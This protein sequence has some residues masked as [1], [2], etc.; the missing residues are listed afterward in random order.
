VRHFI[1]KILVLFVLLASLASQQAM[2]LDITNVRFGA[3]PD[4]TRMVVDLNKKTDFRTFVLPRIDNKPYRLVVDLPSFNWKAGDIP[5][6]A[7]TPVIDVRSGT[8]S[9]NTKRIVVDLKQAV[10]I[11]GA[12]ILPPSGAMPHRLVIDF[13]NIT[14]KNFKSSE[15]KILGDL[16]VEIVS[17]PSALQKIITSQTTTTKTS[18]AGIPIP[19]RKP[20]ASQRTKITSSVAT[21]TKFKIRT[22]LRKRLIVIDAGHGGQDPGAIGAGRAYE[23]NVTL[24]AA[25]VLRSKLQS[26]GR[27]NVIL[28][29]DSDKYLK[30]YQRRNIARKK[31]ADLFISLHADS[32]GKSNVRGASIYTLS[33]KS[34]DAQTAKLAARENQ[35]DLIAGVD[36]SHEDKDVANILIDLAMRDTM[37]QSKFFANTVVNN[38]KNHGIRTLPK[39][40]RYAGFAVL[41]SPDVLSVLVEMGFMSNKSEARLLGT[42]NYQNKMASA[43]TKSIDIYF[44]KVRKNNNQ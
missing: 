28:T 25:R 37:N 26:T 5:Q 4:K 43:L 12:F 3:H 13:T 6:P 41:K 17:T 40:H 1:L 11:K 27:Y 20:A 8:L 18:I 35:V 14:E 23:K 16:K 44:Q 29:R 36:L 10:R 42:R 15:Q 19:K 21:A 2:A 22:P 32:I 31:N 7:K 34:S 24:A 39:P 33:N 9:S 38:M 30:L